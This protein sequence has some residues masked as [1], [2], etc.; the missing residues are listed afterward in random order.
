M[1]N[2]FDRRLRD[3]AGTLP[4]LD[5]DT[6]L[7]LR[8]RRHS[9]RMPYAVLSLVLVAA[10]TVLFLR[11]D[12]QVLFESGSE[13]PAI[14]TGRDGS[15]ASSP[16]AAD[17]RVDWRV[18]GVA[19]SA[20][21]FGNFAYDDPAELMAAWT[22]RG[23]TNPPP[24]I[25]EG[26]MIAFFA[27]AG[28]CTSESQL[29]TVEFIDMIDGHGKLLAAVVDP[30]CAIIDR[31]G[32]TAEGPVTQY[33]VAVRHDNDVPI[34]AVEPVTASVS[35]LEWRALAEGFDQSGEFMRTRATD[36]ETLDWAWENW[37]GPEPP[38]LPPETVAF[39][40]PMPGRCQGTNAVVAVSARGLVFEPGFGTVTLTI[41]FAEACSQQQPTGSGRHVVAIG[42]DS[43]VG[44]TL[45]GPSIA[46]ACDSRGQ[47]EGCYSAS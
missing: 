34:R 12:A 3:V 5:D 25:N 23:F 11:D 43:S 32:T 39:L 8:R 33:A 20:G 26:E 17:P 4:H 45:A 41:E 44:Q 10:A 46:I 22:E 35:D 16:S 21:R 42:L 24:E 37:I 31:F 15:E 30:S 18:V 29:R 19:R 14:S 27:V 2:S 36:Q 38:R 7:E 28:T 40:A 9:R 1:S 47:P 13:G 6:F